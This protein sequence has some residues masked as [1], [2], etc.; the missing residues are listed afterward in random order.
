MPEEE[1]DISSLFDWVVHKANCTDPL[2]KYECACAAVEFGLPGTQDANF[3]FMDASRLAMTSRYPADWR[4]VLSAGALASEVDGRFRATVQIRQLAAAFDTLAATNLLTAP[5]RG[6]AARTM[7]EQGRF[8][9]LNPLAGPHIPDRRADFD[10]VYAVVARELAGTPEPLLLKGEFYLQWAWDAR[11]GGTAAEVSEENMGLFRERL[12]IAQ[13]ALSQAYE[14]DKSDPRAAVAMVR[15]CRG[16]GDDRPA[17]EKWFNRAMAA[18]PDAY[19][20]C[21]QKLEYLEPFW[22]GNG[23][24]DEVQ[25]FVRECRESGNFRGRIPLILV[26]AQLRLARLTNDPA[27]YLSNPHV[28]EGIR[29]AYEAQLARFPDD[30]YDRTRYATLAAWSGQSGDAMRQFNILGNSPW[31]NATLGEGLKYD[32]LKERIMK[33]QSP[34]PPK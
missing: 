28:W 24:L 23:R 1:A 17:M 3:D 7:I 12:G 15:A 21:A 22:Y 32:E 6:L 33:L 4:A 10:R 34:A 9:R 8:L 18:D 14:L 31:P 16:L 30:R 13:E 20:A 5:E 19:E 11:G 27:A 26:D 2:V 25:K 29:G